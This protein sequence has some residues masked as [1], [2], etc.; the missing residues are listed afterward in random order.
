[1][2][3]TGLQGEWDVVLDTDLDDGVLLPSLIASMEKQGLTLTR[4]TLPTEKLVIDRVDKIPTE[5]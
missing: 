5:N 3:A 2:D 1:V 4:T